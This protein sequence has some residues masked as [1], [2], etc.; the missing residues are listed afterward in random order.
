MTSSKPYILRA[1]YEWL[2]DNDMTPHL[3]VDANV[4]EVLVP[5][6]FVQDGRIILNI[7]PSA[8]QSLS[9][10]NSDVTFSAR[11][12][13]KPFN[14]YLP[15]GAI[16]GIYAKENGQG[17]MFKEDDMDG[18]EPPDTDPPEPEKPKRPRPQLRVV[19]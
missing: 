3:L 2:L 17:T 9:L 8:V 1:I 7:A 19:K 4:E 14:L 15:M 16:L 10:E 11:F 12:S 5:T 18:D 13:G 6:Q